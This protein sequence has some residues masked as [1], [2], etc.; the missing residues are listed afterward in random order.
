MTIL[1]SGTLMGH[2]VQ[3]SRG[4]AKGASPYR[5]T[6]DDAFASRLGRGIES[7][8]KI[9]YGRDDRPP[10]KV[11]ARH[12]LEAYL[13][14]GDPYGLGSFLAEIDAGKLDLETHRLTRDL[15]L[16]VTRAHA[17]YGVVAMAFATDN[18]EP[19]RKALEREADALRQW[20]LTLREAA[21][22][23]GGVST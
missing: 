23:T 9:L 2:T 8:K 3:P 7:A 20:L 13:E 6:V 11:L 22:L 5:R 1:S 14:A 21:R 16:Q 12:A 4:P 15:M 10:L 18:S 19:N 17:S